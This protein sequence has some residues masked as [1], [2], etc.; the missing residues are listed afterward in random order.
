MSASRE[1]LEMVRREVGLRFRIREVYTARGGLGFVIEPPDDLEEEF[2]DLRRELRPLGMVVS[3]DDKDGRVTVFV[4]NLPRGRTRP[5]S[6]NQ[7]MLLLTF[8]TTVVSGSLLWASF[9]GEGGVFE[10]HNLLWGALTFA[11][12]LLLILGTH[13]LSHYLM[14][15]RYGLSVSLPFFIPSIPPVGT[16]GAFISI[17][18]PLPSRKALV[19]IGLA[20][21]F[22]GFLVAI[23]VLAIGYSLSIGDSSTLWQE[24]LVTFFGMPLIM[25]A[26]MFLFPVGGDLLMHPTMFA[27]W[28]GLFITG[29]NLLPAGQLDGG[30]VS[31]AVLGDRAVYVGYVVMG[32]LILLSTVYTGW[33]IFGLLILM[34]GVSH[35]PPLNDITPLDRKR[36][37]AAA[38]GLVLLITC[39]IPVP[40]ESR[41]NQPSLSLQSDE[42]LEMNISAGG[43]VQFNF[44]MENDGNMPLLVTLSLD[45]LS[46]GWSHMFTVLESGDNSSSS[47]QVDLDAG[48]SVQIRLD[49]VADSNASV[50]MYGLELGVSG[51]SAH[52][53]LSVRLSI[54]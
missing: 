9:T 27:G 31:R 24:G 34:L 49:V 25:Q 41:L 4:V 17:R 47:L 6:V 40:M 42:P 26:M 48:Q 12:P 23:P 45:N 5:V 15:K 2:E 33:L 7:F 10:V 35:P 11:V 50:G 20:G 54:V 8:V 32:A 39:F 22:G 21:P 43:G 16:F 30:H 44:T 18:E 19:D 52:D 3:V 1:I 38:I 28:L 36:Y 51:G 14:S 53:S 29:I 37:L 46:S 13:E